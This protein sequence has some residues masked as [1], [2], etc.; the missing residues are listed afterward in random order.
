[1]LK[2]MLKKIMQ[3]A[4][5]SIDSLMWFLK[6]CIRCKSLCCVGSYMWIIVIG[7]MGLLS[8]WMV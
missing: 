6:S 2:S 1:M 5:F 3:V 7:C 8:V 4:D